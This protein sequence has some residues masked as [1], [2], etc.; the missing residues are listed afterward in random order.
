MS[1]SALKRSRWW[2]IPA[3]VVVML[4][5][6]A[7]VAVAAVA[8]TD[9]PGPSANYENI[10]Q[11]SLV[12]PMDNDKQNLS[13]APFNL[14]AYGLVAQLLSREIPVKWAIRSGKPKDGIDFSAEASQVF[15]TGQKG[16]VVDFRGGP[17]IIEEQYANAARFYI[18]AYGNDVAVYEI[19]DKKGADIDIRHT[20]NQMRRVAVLNDGGNQQIHIKILNEAGFQ[21][22]VHYVAVPATSLGTLNAGSCYTTATEPHFEK[23]GVDIEAQAVR[24]YLLSGGNFLVTN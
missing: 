20:I 4:T 15:P 13:G 23:L 21:P 24:E 1:R 14:K 16:A 19:D 5:A 17:F 18:Q 10:P 2:E 11:G 6:V 9:L 12:I 8:D 7:V 22:G 3:V